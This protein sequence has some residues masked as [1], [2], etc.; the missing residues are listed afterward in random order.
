MACP[1]GRE[2]GREEGGGRPLIEPFFEK[3]AKAA[4]AARG[5][6]LAA[7]VV[8]MLVALIGPLF[9][10]DHVPKPV[11]IEG[12]LDAERLEI[13]ALVDETLFGHWLALD[14]LAVR[15]LDPEGVGDYGE[16]GELLAQW[17]D[18]YATVA[19]DGI[20]VRPVID[21]IEFQEGFDVNDYLNFIGVTAVYGTKSPPKEIE[22]SWT[23]FDSED[24]YPLEAVFLTL[25][26]GDDFQIYKF[27]EDDPLKVWTPP[28][29]RRVL[30][31]EEV[32]PGIREPLAVVSVTSLILI[33]VGLLLGFL[34]R[35]AKGAAIA[36]LVLALFSAWMARTITPWRVFLPWQSAVVL[37]S[38]EDSAALFETLHRNIYR[39]FDYNEEGAAYDAI[40]RSVSGP[41]LETTYDEVYRSLVMRLEEDAVCEVR[42]VR[43]TETIVEIPDNP[44][45]PV[46]S[47]RS[48]W[49][50]IGT[51]RHWGH[52]HWRTNLYSARYRVRW[53]EGTGWRIDKVEILDQ[54]RIDDGTEGL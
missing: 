25:S 27:M 54:R 8:L 50:V 36:I 12:D 10:T 20:Q 16:Y 6:S 37:P 43:P 15:D 17:F 44:T 33:L 26:T 53:I 24:R 23:R 35:Q 34:L 28:E 49:Q 42:A 14:P 30:S 21:D 48:R 41:L 31:P 5:V 39:A 2:E 11:T 19:I 7:G 46:F 22:F 51:V 3:K 1:R 13:Y 45:E 29:G 47:V 52:G 18:N 9:A 4:P 38:E 40:S 32:A